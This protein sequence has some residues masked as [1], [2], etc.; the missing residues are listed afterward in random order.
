MF[1]FRKKIEPV[2]DPPPKNQ[3]GVLDIYEEQATE[4]VFSVS[5]FIDTNNKTTKTTSKTTG[6]TV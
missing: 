6:L 1:F 2:I 3:K 5:D 4:T